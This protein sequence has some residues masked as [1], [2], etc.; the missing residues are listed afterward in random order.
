[1]WGGSFPAIEAGV[2]PLGPFLLMFGRLVLGAVVLFA[3]VLA[4]RPPGRGLTL[5]ESLA[6]GAL[7]AAMPFVLISY[8][9]QVLPASLASVL[10][11]TTPV[12]GLLV[13]AAVI[14]ER[15]APGRLAGVVASALLLGSG[16]GCRPG[17]RSC[18][19]ASRW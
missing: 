2:E 17:A 5:R 18:S 16:S 12:F 8:G 19:R 4:T 11:A 1:M 10:N 13:G 15:L 3:V 7:D 14:G 6:L 9:S